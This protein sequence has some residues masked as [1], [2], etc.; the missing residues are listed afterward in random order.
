MF[1]ISFLFDVSDKEDASRITFDKRIQVRTVTLDGD[2]YEPNGTLT[3][4][5]APSNSAVLTKLAALKR[6]Q[7]EL[8][9]LQA[10][11][12][13]LHQK[14]GRAEAQEAAL[15]DTQHALDILQ[16]QLG[17]AK[18]QFEA[19]PEGK[20]IT[21]HDDLNKLIQGS[22][23]RLAK[24]AQKH[25]VLQ[26]RLAQCQA[27]SADFAGDKEGKLRA[28]KVCKIIID[29]STDQWMDGFF[30]AL[31]HSFIFYTLTCRKQWNRARS[32]WRGRLAKCKRNT[33]HCSKP[34][35]T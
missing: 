13:A 35:P 19:S 17:V 21:R 8:H 5:K 34:K 2:V 3:G 31:F 29:L 23:E 32:S 25:A 6:A 16:R 20:L 22:Q 33:R 24:L 11:Y 18:R 7:E 4:G 10:S 15:H 1:E 27:D 9:D 14:L 26:A 28:L 12:T 30:V